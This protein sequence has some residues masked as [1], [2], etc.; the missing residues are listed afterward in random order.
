MLSRM[1][2]QKWLVLILVTISLVALIVLSAGLQNL[3][4]K[5]GQSFRLKDL[6]SNHNPVNDMVHQFVSVP[7]W[8]QG[9][10][11]ILALLLILLV[12]TLL[13]PEY[14]KRF[15]RFILSFLLSVYV[16]TYLIEN[17]LITLPEIEL[18]AKAFQEAGDK[19][20]D[21]LPPPSLFSPPELSNWVYF[22][23]SLGII[24]LFLVIVWGIMRWWKKINQL[25]APTNTLT[26]I[27][28]I[29]R[30]SL[31]NLSTGADW[32]DAI[33]NCYV[34]MS[35]AIDR[36]RGITRQEAMT[37]GEFAIRLERA[38]LPADSVRKLT[39]LFESVR[40]GSH[41]PAG[42]EINEAVACLNSILHYCGEEI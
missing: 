20:T 5:A 40:Y 17:K 38:G 37:P 41:K 39:N 23:I 26:D 32:A 30:S 21:T 19:S 6:Q 9:A 14:R 1:F 16:F 25:Y 4:L 31:D 28:L 18:G 24:L 22:M 3:Q 11:Y 29:A 33:T 7:T 27:A 13:S 35:E 42:N 15:I 12:A 2:K 36:T 10:F 8:K 34:R